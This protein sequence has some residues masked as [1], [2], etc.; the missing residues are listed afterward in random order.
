MPD[1][2]AAEVEEAKRLERERSKKA[3]GRSGTILTGETRLGAPA[4]QRKTLLGQ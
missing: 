2:G 3:A 1:A 4:G